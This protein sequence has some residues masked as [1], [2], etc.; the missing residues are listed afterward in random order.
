M[1]TAT[2]QVSC[3]G[4]TTTLLYTAGGSGSTV[5]LWAN[6]PTWVGTSSGVTPTTGI[7]L[8]P[9]TKAVQITLAAAETLYGLTAARPVPQVWR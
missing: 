4:T 8:Q 5:L 9:D 6:Q 7:P 2:S 3:N 1:A